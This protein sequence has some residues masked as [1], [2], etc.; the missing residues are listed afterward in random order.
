MG[1]KVFWLIEFRRLHLRAKKF[2]DITGHHQIT[3]WILISIITL[4]ILAALKH[5]IIDKD[6]VVREL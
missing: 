5:G 1:F 4:H 3:G 2:I 6:R